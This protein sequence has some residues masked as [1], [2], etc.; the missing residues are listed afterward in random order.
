MAMK[1]KPA[2]AAKSKAKFSQ[3]LIVIIGVVAI[4]V[5]LIVTNSLTSQAV[6]DTVDVAYLI[7]SIPKDGTITSAALF[8]KREMLAMEY[9]KQGLSKL[10]GG[11]PIREVLLWSDLQYVLPNTEANNKAVG[12]T[13]SGPGAYAAAYMAGGRP[14]YWSDLTTTTTQK[15]SY[16]YQMDGELIRLDIT[17]DD[18]GDMVV[19]GD[20]L[21]VRITYQTD[22]YTLPSYD[23][24]E[25]LQESGKAQDNT[26][27][28]TELLFSEVTILDMINGSGES[29]FDLYYELLSL[30]DAEKEAIINSADFKSRVAPSNILLSVTAEEADRYAYIKTMGG[31]YLITLLPRDGTTEILDAL[32]E[33]KTGFARN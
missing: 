14:V 20:K 17:P 13:C 12:L 25:K 9:E 18:F 10:G 29:I 5:G 21:N 22:D 8:E 2:K 23:E 19:P 4:F 7:D 24:Y 27:T 3:T 33:L 32:D 26:I 31:T 11:Q 30:P 1:L 28:K 15:N 16:L 6:R